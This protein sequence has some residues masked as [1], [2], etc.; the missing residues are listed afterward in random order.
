MSATEPAC[1]EPH[2]AA[3]LACYPVTDRICSCYGTLKTRMMTG[4]LIDCEED[5]TLRAVLVG[6]LR[7]EERDVCTST[8]TLNV[9]LASAWVGHSHLGGRPEVQAAVRT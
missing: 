1:R 9:P 7:E 8:A 5:R 6:M 2:S 3:G 4:L